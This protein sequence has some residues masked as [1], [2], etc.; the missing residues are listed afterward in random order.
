MLPLKK[1]FDENIITTH[2][3]LELI[4]KEDTTSN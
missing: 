3:N 2:G 1:D 4:K